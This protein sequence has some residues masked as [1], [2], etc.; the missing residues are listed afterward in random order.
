MRTKRERES[1]CKDVTN[2]SFTCKSK[3][4]Q[5]HQQGSCVKS[6]EGKSSMENQRKLC[7]IFFKYFI[8]FKSHQAIKN[9][10]WKTFYVINYPCKTPH[11]ETLKTA[12]FINISYTW[13]I[14]VQQ[15]LLLLITL[16]EH[17]PPHNR[18]K[19]VAHIFRRMWGERW[20]MAKFCSP[21]S[22]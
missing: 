12:S 6:R 10:L 11:E 5:I 9:S 15:Y 3:Q 19:V 1:R 2:E 4:M 22:N 20:F 17:H 16:C 21:K 13:R 18:I 7:E 8:D 14:W